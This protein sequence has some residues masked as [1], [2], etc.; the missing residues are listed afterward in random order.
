MALLVA[1]MMVLSYLDLTQPDV[2]LHLLFEEAVLLVD[3]RS[4]NQILDLDSLPHF[5][6]ASSV[7]S[8]VHFDMH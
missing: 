6:S 8:D 4:L 7:P 5:F 1:P 3:L 2:S